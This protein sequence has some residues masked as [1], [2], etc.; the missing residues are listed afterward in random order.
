MVKFAASVL[1]LCVWVKVCVFMCVSR[2]DIWAPFI[3]RDKV[4]SFLTV[5][6]VGLGKP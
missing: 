3:R 4:P 2:G 5:I 1:F 6:L